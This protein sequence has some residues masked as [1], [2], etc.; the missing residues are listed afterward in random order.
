MSKL[1]AVYLLCALELLPNRLLGMLRSAEVKFVQILDTRHQIFE[2]VA[3]H[4][5]QG[6]GL[7]RWNNRVSFDFLLHSTF[8]H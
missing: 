1:F 8:H 2:G 5:H 6:L 7:R 3:S 4:L